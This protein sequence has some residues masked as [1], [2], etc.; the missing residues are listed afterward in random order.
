[1]TYSKRVSKG[2]NCQLTLSSKFPFFPILCRRKVS[3]SSTQSRSIQRLNARTNDDC[4]ANWL[5]K[6][7]HWSLGIRDSDLPFYTLFFAVFFHDKS[8]LFVYKV[9]SILCRVQSQ[10]FELSLF[11]LILHKKNYFRCTHNTFSSHIREIAVLI[12]ATVR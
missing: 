7:D 2:E 5:H 1:M 4:D 8:Q 10:S 11:V 3:S 6:G 12:S 9:L